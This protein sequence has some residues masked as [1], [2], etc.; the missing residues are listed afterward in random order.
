MPEGGISEPPGGVSAAAA[1]SGREFEPRSRILE[2]R[3]IR[4]ILDLRAVKDW[5][6]AISENRRSDAIVWRQGHNFGDCATERHFS[7]VEGNVFVGI[8]AHFNRLSVKALLERRRW[9]R[10]PIL[11]DLIFEL[12][13][14]LPGARTSAAGPGARQMFR[15]LLVSS[16]GASAE[17]CK[18]L[19]K[20]PQAHRGAIGRA[21]MD[22]KASPSVAFRIAGGPEIL[23][24]SKLSALSP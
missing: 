22:F 16:R 14:T 23:W 1:G 21:P 8:N 2:A 5:R 9:R 3:Q 17:W 18:R 4:D 24:L 10:C 20:S 13:K 19:A 15:Y 11:L 7:S 12:L 6:F